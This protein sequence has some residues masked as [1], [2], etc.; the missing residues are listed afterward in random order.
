MARGT[1]SKTIVQFSATDGY[2]DFDKFTLE[3]IANPDLFGYYE[4]NPADLNDGKY[5]SKKGMI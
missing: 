4:K 5:I 1:E 2:K 3:Q